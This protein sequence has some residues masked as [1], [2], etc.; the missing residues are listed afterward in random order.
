MSSDLLILNAL[1]DRSRYDALVTSVPV[2]T[3]SSDCQWL[4]KWYPVYWAAYPTHS[5]L[6][7]DALLAVMKLRGK[8]DPDQQAIAQ[9]VCQR[10]A[11]PVSDDVLQGIT[12]QLQERA[13]AGTAARL[14][15]EYQSGA[16]LDLVQELLTLTQRASENV[17]A[18]GAFL[19]GADIMASLDEQSDGN[20]LRLDFM[21]GFRDGFKS[22][23]PG[24][25]I[26][27][28]AEVD[29]GKTSLIAAALAH[30]APQ[31]ADKY[32]DRPILWLNNEGS[33][34]PIINRM[35]NA[36]LKA[37]TEELW[38]YREDGS[39][40]D[41]YSAA[42]H[43]L[44]RIR[45]VGAHGWGPGQIERCLQAAK[46]AVVVYDM[47]A[48]FQSGSR[49]AEA[50]HDKAER[51]WQLARENA[52]RHNHVSIGTCQLSVNGYDTPYPM[53]T[54]LKDTKVGVQGALEAMILMGSRRSV[55]ELESARWF[56]APKNKRRPTG[57]A[58]VRFQAHFDRDRCVFSDGT[59][60]GTEE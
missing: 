25:N 40:L 10:L 36:A 49:G 26:L 31:V 22:F 48:N 29:A 44:N 39:L 34:T 58:A 57:A 21:Q 11:A 16:E 38:Q 54:D 33:N 46:P 1:R 5:T 8:M 13:L 12:L 45:V 9:A 3:L 2:D 56:S 51:L 28:A 17:S 47:M 18:E 23:I 27:F 60:A 37:T 35:Y 53:M 15:T 19:G 24:D 6:N 30:L 20:G 41:R 7:T 50:N 52:V 42:V 4:L 43:G 55:P 32:G 59:V 14:I